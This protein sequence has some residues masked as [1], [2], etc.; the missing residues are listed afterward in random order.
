MS[1]ETVDVDAL[2]A[3]MDALERRNQALEERIEALEADGAAGG[4]SAGR[5]GDRRDHA[6]LDSLEHGQRVSTA[7]LRAAYR[8]HTDI[9]SASTLKGRIKGLVASD[10]FE[11]V[12]PG[13]WRYMGGEDGD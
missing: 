13:A 10:D 2:L 11:F 4:E 6:V 3:R 7:S 5:Y 9:T 12:R 1:G 8:T